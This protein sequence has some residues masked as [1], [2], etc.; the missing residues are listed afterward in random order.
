VAYNPE[1]GT[2]TQGTDRE[3]ALGNLRE[4]TALYV[5]EFPE[6]A[7]RGTDTTLASFEVDPAH[8]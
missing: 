5:E 7:R 4:A 8:A 6:L 3:D 1:T 2:T